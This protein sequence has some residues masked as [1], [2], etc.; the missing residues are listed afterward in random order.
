[1]PL[2]STSSAVGTSV[3]CTCD[4]TLRPMI[5]SLPHECERGVPNCMLSRYTVTIQWSTKTI[6]DLPLLKRRAPRIEGRGPLVPPAWNTLPGIVRSLSASWTVRLECPPCRTPVSPKQTSASPKWTP[7]LPRQ[8]IALPKETSALHNVPST[9]TNGQ[10]DCPQ[11]VPPLARRMQVKLLV[12]AE[13]C[14]NLQAGRA[15]PLR[16]LLRQSFCMRRQSRQAH[17]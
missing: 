4:K 16:S 2:A 5:K 9:N 8:T 11:L 6:M 14:A 15:K 13:G 10:F 12:H 1:L 3:Q 17:T 7:A